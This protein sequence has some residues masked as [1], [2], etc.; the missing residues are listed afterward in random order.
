MKTLN[1]IT[2]SLETK[3]NYRTCENI[4]RHTFWN[5][6]VKGASEHL[7]VHKLREHKDFIKDLAFTISYKDLKAGDSKEEIAGAIYFSQAKIKAWKNNQEDLPIITLGPLFIDP[8]FQRLGFGSI[9]INYAINKAK[10]QGYKAIVLLGN[11]KYYQKFNFEGAKQ[12]NVSLEDGKYYKALQLLE[13][14]SG[15]LDNIEGYVQFSDVFNVTEDEIEAFDNTFDEKLEKFETES[16]K[17][18]IKLS[19]LIDE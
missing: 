8:K 16:Q 14:E 5:L 3:E 10:E 13:L 9:L 4:A 15:Y 12:Y 2:I 1:K 7:I 11:P 17:E 19:T 18:Y 6:Y